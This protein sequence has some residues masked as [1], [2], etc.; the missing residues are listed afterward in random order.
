MKE[1]TIAGKGPD[2]SAET[3][4]TDLQV[5]K[6]NGAENMNKSW[7]KLMYIVNNGSENIGTSDANKSPQAL[8]GGSA[9]GATTGIISLEQRNG[10]NP[11]QPNISEPGAIEVQ[12]ERKDSEI[13][14]KKLPHIQ[15]ALAE[16]INTENRADDKETLADIERDVNEICDKQIGEMLGDEVA[17]ISRRLLKTLIRREADPIVQN[18]IELMKAVRLPNK[19]EIIH[20][21]FDKPTVHIIGMPPDNYSPKKSI[22]LAMDIQELENEGISVNMSDRLDSKQK[23]IKGL[24]IAGEQLDQEI[25]SQVAQYVKKPKEHLDHMS[26]MAGKVVG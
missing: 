6:G 16:M 22:V 21:T 10:L 3:G 25:E 13:A 15:T 24:A 1:I 9:E 8:G 19:L 26:I 4:E 20:S 14:R 11:D 18:I 7:G 17:G 23:A 2:P 12:A 5:T